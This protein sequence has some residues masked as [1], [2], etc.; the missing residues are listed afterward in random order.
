M[1]TFGVVCFLVV[2]GVGLFVLGY[3]KGAQRAWY[4]AR[5]RL[6][7]TLGS[8]RVPQGDHVH[9]CSNKPGEG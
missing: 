1:G 7:E 6:E 3:L 9:R 5:V 2:V 4:Q 8:R